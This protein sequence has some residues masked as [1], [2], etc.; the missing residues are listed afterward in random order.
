[1]CDFFAYTGIA[2][3]V[4]HNEVEGGTG[5]ASVLIHGAAAILKNLL[6]QVCTL[7]RLLLEQ[8][9]AKLHKTHILT[10]HVDVHKSL[11]FVS[12]VATPVNK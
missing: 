2:V 11:W 1:M 10:R 8:Q 6:A 12:A 7:L 3:A 5:L 9:V 4:S